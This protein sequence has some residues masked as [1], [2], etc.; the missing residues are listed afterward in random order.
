MISHMAFVVATV[1]YNVEEQWRGRVQM[2]A[3]YR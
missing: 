3:A 1:S 2:H